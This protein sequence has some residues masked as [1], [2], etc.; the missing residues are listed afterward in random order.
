MEHDH[1]QLHILSRFQYID[2]GP[3]ILLPR[4]QLPLIMVYDKTTFLYATICVNHWMDDQCNPLLPGNQV[5][6]HAYTFYHVKTSPWRC[7]S[8]Y[9]R[10]EKCP[11]ASISAIS[12][13]WMRLLLPRMR[14]QPVMVTF[15]GSTSG[16][17]S[18]RQFP[19]DKWP[20][21]TARPGVVSEW[22]VSPRTARRPPLYTTWQGVSY[23]RLSGL[24]YWS[25]TSLNTASVVQLHNRLAK[26]VLPYG[27]YR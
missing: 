16:H 3:R 8:I 20:P 6:Y 12:N 4:F 18:S 23:A 21:R 2:T 17:S 25:C 19:P 14:H 5:Q 7:Y 15:D 22:L 26:V 13:H 24:A 1:N 10:N 11:E 9:L 27:E